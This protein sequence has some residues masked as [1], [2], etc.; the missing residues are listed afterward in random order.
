LCELNAITEAAIA[1]CDPLDG[2]TDGIISGPCDFDPSTVIGQTVTC[3][4]PDGIVAISEKAAKIAAATWA[5]PSD[6]NGK[7]EW[8]G[9]GYASN[10]SGLANTNCSSTTDCSS[11]PFTITADWLKIFLLGDPI[12]DLSNLTH[13]EYS[14]LLRQSVNKYASVI[15]TEDPDLT[16]FKNAGGKMITWHGTADQ[17][18]PFN[19]TVDYY[20]RVLQLDPSAADYYR[21]FP[22]PGVAH[23]H[24]GAGWYPGDAFAS[25]INWVENGTA[26]ETLY[27]EVIWGD[28][29]E[30]TIRAVDLCAYP[31]ALTYI[32]GD[33]NQ[34]SSF[35]CT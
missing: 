1:A 24:N 18:I 26:P 23:C 2:V 14:K 3:S 5:G 16:D 19:G 29:P 10:F 9:L 13:K 15:G 35:T 17:L 20:E 6:E 8:Y 27:A 7:F 25:L 31:K 12:A 30:N 28:N 11:S 21:F 34:P 33:G 22:A 4:D 32:G